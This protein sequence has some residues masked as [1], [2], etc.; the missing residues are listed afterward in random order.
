MLGEGYL[1][2]NSSYEFFGIGAATNVDYVKIHWLS[3]IV[4]YIENPAINTHHTYI[5][6]ENILGTQEFSNEEIHIFPNP[7]SETVT[8]TFPEVLAGSMITLRDI[9]GRTMFQEK[10]ASVLTQLE[11]GHLSNGIYMVSIE[12]GETKIS[13]K[14][15]VE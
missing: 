7:A 12:N 3:G 10:N 4:D 9:T 2:Q 11:V 14:I 1:G 15:I 5:E 13:E 8:I 6:G